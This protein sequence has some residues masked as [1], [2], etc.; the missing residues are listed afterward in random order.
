M[1]RSDGRSDRCATL[2]TLAALLDWLG[3]APSGTSIDAAALRDTLSALAPIEAPAPSSTAQSAADAT[4]PTWRERL[5]VAP[6]ETRMGVRDVAEA[7]A[8]RSRSSTVAPALR[9]F[10]P[11]ARRRADIHGRRAAR[12]ARGT[13]GKHHAGTDCAGSALDAHR[14][15]PRMTRVSASACSC[16]RVLATSRA[17]TPMTTPRACSHR[18]QRIVVRPNGARVQLCAGCGRV[19]ATVAAAPRSRRQTSASTPGQSAALSVAQRPIY[20]A[21]QAN[22][23]NDAFGLRCSDQGGRFVPLS[24]EPESGH[25]ALLAAR[26][27]ACR[28]AVVDACGRRAR[29]RSGEAP[30]AR[31]GDDGRAQRSAGMPTR[32]ETLDDATKLAAWITLACLRGQIDARTAESAT[33][34]VRQFQLSREKKE[35]VDRIRVLEKALAAAQKASV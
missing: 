19:L 35:L 29:G 26:R 14:R 34:G 21:R 8:G 24:D 27:D 12:V 6:A 17:D 20:N 25:R 3:S 23:D 18:R 2:P 28:R 5:W 9:R 13:R 33:K 32:L 22:D 30:G 16:G 10:A 15:T 11:E 4:A 7:L 1:G 31:G